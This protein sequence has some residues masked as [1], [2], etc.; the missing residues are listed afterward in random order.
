MRA[1]RVEDGDSAARVP[2]G[3]ELVAHEMKGGDAPGHD[4][5]ARSAANQPVANCGGKRM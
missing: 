1:D 4:S 3:D 5:S 2:E